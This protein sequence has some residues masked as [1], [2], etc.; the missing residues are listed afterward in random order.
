MQW[1]AASF[2]K[3][4]Y[5]YLEQAR[6][7]PLPLPRPQP[8]SYF[9]LSPLHRNLDLSATQEARKTVYQHLSHTPPLAPSRNAFGCFSYKQSLVNNN[10]WANSTCFIYTDQFYLLNMKW[11]EKKSFKAAFLKQII[12]YLGELSINNDTKQINKCC[13]VIHIQSLLQVQILETHI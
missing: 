1:K 4:G 5:V 2:F 8:C 6:R 10:I 12:H 13:L 3:R 11:C 9:L 7:S